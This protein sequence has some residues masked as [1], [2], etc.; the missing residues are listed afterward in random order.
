MAYND[1]GTYL[2]GMKEDVFLK[3]LNDDIFMGQVWPG[4]VYFPD[5]LNPKTTEWW[6]H[7]IRRFHEKVP[8]DGM[9]ID[10]NEIANFCSGTCSWNG[11][12]YPDNTNCYLQCTPAHSKYDDPPFMLNHTGTYQP[13]NYRTAPM[14]VKHHDGNIQ[15]NTHSLFGISESKATHI[16]MTALHLPGL[17]SIHGAL[18]R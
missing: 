17:G 6:T 4:P 15:Y 7:E 14:T 3:H 8:F 13:L 16:A 10:M 1:Y 2:R 9:W 11:T 12:I 5:F 18:D